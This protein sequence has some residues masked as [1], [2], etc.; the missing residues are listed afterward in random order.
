MCAS[1]VGFGTTEDVI[2]LVIVY[3]ATFARESVWKYV[4]S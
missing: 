4:K 2:S 1:F 3:F